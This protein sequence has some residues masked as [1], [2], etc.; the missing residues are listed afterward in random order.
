MAFAIVNSTFAQ[1]TTGSSG[2]VSPGWTLTAGH[3]LVVAVIPN[4]GSNSFAASPT[5]TD[6]AGNTYTVR[7]GVTNNTAGSN[8]HGFW[9]ADTVISTGGSG[10]TITGNW[11]ASGDWNLAVLEYSFANT[12]AY[13]ATAASR[14]GDVAT[15]SFAPGSL[16][17][18]G[19]GRLVVVGATWTLSSTETASFGAGFEVSQLGASS[20]NKFAIMDATGQ[21]GTISPTIT[22]NSSQR[23]AAAAA[24]Y[25][26]SAG[27]TVSVP[28]GLLFRGANAGLVGI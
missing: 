27:V 23:F 11:G 19:S 12:L 14:G 17:L 21:S 2:T 5:V 6:S 26:E 10:V 13:D 25:Y 20:I 16:A 18:T 3:L 8:T 24:S 22:S 1:G 4:S 28:F 15:T 9:F 7:C